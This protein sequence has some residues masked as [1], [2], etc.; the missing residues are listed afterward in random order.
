MA[1]DE[2]TAEQE[3][4]IE[5]ARATLIAA[6][7]GFADAQEPGSYVDG[8]MVLTHRLGVGEENVGYSTVHIL[9][10]QDQSWVMTRGIVEAARDRIRSAHA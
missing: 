10:D 6:I 9:V 7:R 3:E 8:F 2:M 5:A 1:D 4:R